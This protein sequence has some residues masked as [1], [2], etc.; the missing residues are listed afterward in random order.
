V[1]SD[2]W[3]MAAMIR[4]EP[5]RHKRHVAIKGASMLTQI[6]F[7]TGALTGI[8]G[9]RVQRAGPGAVF[10]SAGASPKMLPT[11]FSSTAFLCRLRAT[12]TLIR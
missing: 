3:V 6:Q 4:S 11:R 8:I 7:S 9:A 5:R 2:S 1:I 10:H 12:K